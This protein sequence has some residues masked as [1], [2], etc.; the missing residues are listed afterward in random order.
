MHYTVAYRSL[1]WLAVTIATLA[2]GLL[3]CSQHSTRPLP[4]AYH[5][6]NAHFNAYYIAN[7]RIDEVERL[8]FKNRQDNYNQLLPILLPVDSVVTQPYKAQLDD[9]IKKAS[10]VPQRHQNSKWVDDSYILIGKARLYKQDLLNAIEVFKYVNTKGTNDDDKHTALVGLM[11]AYVEGADY[12][13]G[14]NVAEYLRVQPLNAANTRDFYLTKAYLHEK[15][16]EYAIAAAI[17]EATFPLLKRGEATARLH[18][19]AGQLYDQL[20]QFTKAAAHYRAVLAGRPNYDQEFYANIHLMQADGNDPRQAAQATTQFKRMLDDRKNADLKDKIYFTMGQLE[21]RRGNVDK[22]LALFR[23]SVQ[24]TSTNTVQVPFTY[25]EMAKIYF[26]QKRDYPKAQAH[27]DSAVALLPQTAPEYT[28]V[29]TRK[30]TLDEFVEHYTT[31]RTEDSLQRLA[32]MNPAALDKLLD[33]II[34]QRIREDEQ[35]AAI[36][37]QIAAKAAAGQA[38]NSNVAPADRWILYN[39]VRLGQAKQEFTQKWGNRPLEDN[40]RRSNKEPS[41]TLA[42]TDTPATA[43]PNA[44]ATVAQP[45]TGKQ[46]D[47]ENPIASTRKAQKE[48]MYAQIPFS[49][50]ALQQST[51]RLETAYYKLG[52]VYKFQLEQP[53]EAIDTFEQ[54]LTRFPTTTYKPEVYYLVY[55]TNDQ[56]ARPSAYKQRLITEFPNSSYTRLATRSGQAGTP[57]TATGEAGAL[58]TYTTIYELYKGGNQTEALARAEIALGTVAGTQMEDKMALLRVILVGHVQ[59]ADAYRQALAEFIRDYP[60]SPLLPR[61]K[62]LQAA[63]EQPTAKRK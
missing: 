58:Q 50:E 59:G 31:I 63:A 10:L 52:K 14:L 24:A 35:N 61:V 36:A 1:G 48:A 28:T 55:V 33:K 32:A 41:Q 15:K 62:E 11:R 47:V 6:L 26:D 12:A 46:T 20:R 5:N 42:S 34:D 16:G 40:W 17:L 60:T 29:L 18:V 56:L 43:D 45:T 37:R 51:Q 19:I 8:L 21:Q 30:K 53:A 49:K 38:T 7:S 25:V 54:L 27:Y 3:S 4:K 2:G 44:P 9:A 13:N 39:P 57:A 23:Q 22:A